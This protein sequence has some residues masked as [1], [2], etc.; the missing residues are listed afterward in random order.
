VEDK[1]YKKQP[2]LNKA[3]KVGGVLGRIA[4][5]AF[6]VAMAAVTVAGTV[7]GLKNKSKE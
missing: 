6:A 1:E 7:I 5:V 3:A 4:K 2:N